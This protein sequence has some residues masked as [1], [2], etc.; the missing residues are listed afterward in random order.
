M[1]AK[2]QASPE[3]ELGDD[4][5]ATA[6]KERKADRNVCPTYARWLYR[7]TF[8]VSLRLRSAALAGARGQAEVPCPTPFDQVGQAFLPALKF[9]GLVTPELLQSA[10]GP[11]IAQWH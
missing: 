5:R 9:T 1:P 2:P 10:V 8:S 7:N 6:M 4:I 11:A 3:R